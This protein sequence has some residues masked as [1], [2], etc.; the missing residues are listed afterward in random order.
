MVYSD[1]RELRH[2]ACPGLYSMRRCCRSMRG[3][4]HVGK[5]LNYKR[6][7]GGTLAAH[8]PITRSST[9][10]PQRVPTVHS[11]VP[12]GRGSRDLNTLNPRNHAQGQWVH[13]VI[14]EV[15][16]DR[17]T[18]IL[19]LI[20]HKTRK[21]PSLPSAPQQTT[22]RLQASIYRSLLEDLQYMTPAEVSAPPCAVR[23]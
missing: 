7:G 17:D 22:G 14:D 8:R 5:P 4:K 15:Q 1:C 23:A 21:R 6:S 2:S 16:R 18:G 10:S 19:T 12:G 3:I 9:V 13:G 11:R 20:E